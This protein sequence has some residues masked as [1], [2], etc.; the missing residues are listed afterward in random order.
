M[1]DIRED[2]AALFRNLENPDT[3]DRFW[4]RVAEDVDWTVEGTHPLAGRY[5]SKKEFTQATFARLGRLMKDGVRLKLE[6]LY[7][8]GDTTIAELLSSATTIDGAS[9]NNRYCWVCRF[10]GDTIVEVRAYLDSAMVNYT[11]LR[12]ELGR[13]MG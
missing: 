7:V 5:H 9:F 13:T 2:R 8:D 3:H 12:G 10:A 1:T 6:H 4:A 11:V